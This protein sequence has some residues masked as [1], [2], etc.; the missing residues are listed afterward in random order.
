MHLNAGTSLRKERILLS[1]CL[2]SCVSSNLYALFPAPLYRHLLTLHESVF[3]ALEFNEDIDGIGKGKT[4]WFVTSSS[5][6]CI[7]DMHTF[8]NVSSESL[9][10][11]ILSLG[12]E[13]IRKD[14]LNC[15]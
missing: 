7:R 12:L 13:D 3:R 14:L 11:P 5:T 10:I 9:R 8:L 15:A 1:Q 6:D 2:C 4:D